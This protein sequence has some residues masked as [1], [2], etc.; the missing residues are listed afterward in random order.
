MTPLTSVT[1]RVLFVVVYVFIYCSDQCKL[2]FNVV[3]YSILLCSIAVHRN[4]CFLFMF[5]FHFPKKSIFFTQTLS[6][7]NCVF[8][9]LRCGPAG[10]GFAPG[11]TMFL[12]FRTYA[13]PVPFLHVWWFGSG[14]KLP[15]AGAIFWGWISRT[16]IEMKSKHEKKAYISMNGDWT[17]IH[18]DEL[19]LKHNV[20]H[21][22]KEWTQC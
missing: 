1:Q 20:I 19:R 9:A 22:N 15:L 2:S 13:S 17:H 11:N 18:F 10:Q 8:P 4:V 14:L 16:S 21:K 5:W 7:K 3:V 6:R 12:W